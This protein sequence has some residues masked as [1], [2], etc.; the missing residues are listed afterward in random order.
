MPSI[1]LVW[2]ILVSPSRW[3]EKPRD[4]SRCS[5][6]SFCH[7]RNLFWYLLPFHVEILFSHLCFLSM[8]V[9]L[10]EN[11]VEV[12]VLDEDSIDDVCMLDEDSVDACVFMALY[13]ETVFHSEEDSSQGSSQQWGGA[14]LSDLDEATARKIPSTC[15]SFL[16]PHNKCVQ[17]FALKSWIWGLGM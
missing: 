16:L 13:K 5:P 9:E 15:I 14:E 8:L 7:T 6:L 4:W 10:S 1:L 17:E 11:S 2:L 12:C 3:Q